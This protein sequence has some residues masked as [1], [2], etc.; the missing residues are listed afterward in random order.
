MLRTDQARRDYAVHAR[1][2]DQRLGFA[3]RAP[4]GGVPPPPGPCERKVRAA[5]PITVAVVGGFCE[6]S[7]D[8]H[9]LIKDIAATAAEKMQHELGMAYDPAKARMT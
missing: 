2:I 3:P 6:G 4:P 7:E 9:A 5:S 1:D 8:L